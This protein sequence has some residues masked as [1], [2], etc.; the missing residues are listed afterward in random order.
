VY[1][2][3]VVKG[4]GHETLAKEFIDL[5]L[6][7]EMQE[8]IPR[9]EIMFPANTDAEL[10]PAFQEYAIVPQTSLWISLDIVGKRMDEWLH[11]WE[12]VITQP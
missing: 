4:T 5:L 10:P 6:S 7:K 1:G 3:G 12:T 11:A 2:I 8:L 9:T